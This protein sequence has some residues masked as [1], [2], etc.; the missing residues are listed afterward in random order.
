MPKLSIIVPIYNAERYLNRCI[1]SILSQRFTDYEL[2]LVNDGSTDTSLEICNAYASNDDRIKVIE[3]NNSG[4]SATRNAGLNVATGTWITFVDSDDWL[5]E[6]YF[7]LMNTSLCSDLVAGTIFFKSNN[8]ISNLLKD[9][10]ILRDSGY[11]SIIEKELTNPLFNGPYAKF[12][13]KAIIDNLNLRF[14]E[15]LCFG[16]D[17]VFVKEYLLHINSMQ[18]DNTI[19]YNYDDIGDNIYKKYSKSFAP[20]YDYY[21]RM[22]GVYNAIE[23]KF[24]TSLSRK[25]LV[26]VVYNIS[27]VCLR[28]NGLKEWNVIRKFLLDP[29]AR[30]VLRSRGSVHLNNILVLSYDYTGLIFMSYCCFVEWVKHLFDSRYEYIVR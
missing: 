27:A 8:T 30:A 16:E 2:L 12:F 23:N 24:K 26:G 19:I 25:E 14:D 3:K 29:R 9:N 1:D 20:I 10:A 5:S 11:F 6:G 22:S 4:V 28:R 18:I 7:D 21:Q 17:A 13:R 15:R